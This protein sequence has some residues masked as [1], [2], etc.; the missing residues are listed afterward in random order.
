MTGQGFILATFL[1]SA[2]LVWIGFAVLAYRFCAAVLR[3]CQGNSVA[4]GGDAD[5]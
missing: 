3:F 1:V 4:R 2:F 5:E